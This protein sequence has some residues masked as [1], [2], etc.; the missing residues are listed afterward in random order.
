V[1]PGEERRGRK[2]EGRRRGRE[3]GEKGRGRIGGL[4]IDVLSYQKWH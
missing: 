3:K 1:F 2:K 4:G